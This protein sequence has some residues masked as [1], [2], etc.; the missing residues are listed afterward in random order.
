MTF[1]HHYEVDVRWGDMDAYQHVN[2]TLFFRYLESARF[3]YFEDFVLPVLKGKMPI[4]VLAEMQCKF[5]AQIIYPAHLTVKTKISRLGNSSFDVVAE[6]WNGEQRA[7]SSKAVMV[8]LDS[9][10]Y[11]PSKIPDDVV[12]KVKEIEKDL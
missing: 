7:A 11:Q 6:I 12:T 5:E 9:Q 10:T 3:A 4:V 8:W 1:S 2:N